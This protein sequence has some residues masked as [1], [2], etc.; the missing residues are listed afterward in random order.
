VRGPAI[1]ARTSSSCNDL[2]HPHVD[3]QLLGGLPAGRQAHVKPITIAPLAWVKLR[4][5]R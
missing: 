3:A 5:S 2:V 1:A 4:R